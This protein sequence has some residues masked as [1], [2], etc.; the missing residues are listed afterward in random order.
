MGTNSQKTE[1]QEKIEKAK[2]IMAIKFAQVQSGSV[3][4]WHDL[5]IMVEEGI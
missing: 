1:N 2:A 3:A 4:Y 5:S